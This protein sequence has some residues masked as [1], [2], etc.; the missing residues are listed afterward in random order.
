MFIDNVNLLNNIHRN[1]RNIEFPYDKYI[2]DI[3]NYISDSEL[4]YHLD[5][6]I[7]RLN[8]FV[9]LSNI[10][11]IYKIT[12]VKNREHLYKYIRVLESQYYEASLK[13]ML[14]IFNQVSFAFCFH[15][16][17]NLFE[18]ENTH[19]IDHRKSM[20]II[21]IKFSPDSILISIYGS[22]Q[23]IRIDDN[24]SKKVIY[25]IHYSL[26]IS[27]QYIKNVK[28]I[29]NPDVILFHWNYE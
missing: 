8:V 12:K 18:T 29:T 22:F 6:D 23:H 13:K 5:T 24:F 19:V 27:Y 14:F 21:K 11:G 1:I 4:D 3:Y 16:I 17:K 28:I 10:D 9:E 15:A 25:T 2:Q 7:K 20:K 26:I